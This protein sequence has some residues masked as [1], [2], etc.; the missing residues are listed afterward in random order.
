METR[1]IYIYIYIYIKGM[2]SL[3]MKEACLRGRKSVITSIEKRRGEVNLGKHTAFLF[4]NQQLAMSAK[5]HL[6]G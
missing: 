6:S 4:Q 5:P 2:T 1:R 3:G